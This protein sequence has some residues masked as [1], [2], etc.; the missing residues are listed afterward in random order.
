MAGAYGYEQAL[1]IM[2]KLKL[3]KKEQLQ[4]YR[5][6][7]FNVIARNQDDHTKNIA[8]LMNPDGKW[9]L[10]PAF[11][12]TYSHNPAG[13]WTDRHQMTVNGK[14][15]QFRKEDLLAVAA[16]S[17]LKG[18]EQVIQQ[19]L[20]AV[21]QWPEFAGQAGVDKQRIEHIAKQH[22]IYI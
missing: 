15:D 7:V 8:F 16:S 22:R 2:R 19:V 1:M 6:M 14:R 18:A 12:M 11:D 9:S 20:D 10:S 3:S 4:L 5:R 13:E 21:K 17:D